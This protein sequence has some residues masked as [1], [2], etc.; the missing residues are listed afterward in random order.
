MEPFGPLMAFFCVHHF[1]PTLVSEWEICVAFR[2]RVEGDAERRD[3]LI[4][5]KKRIDSEDE[6]STDRLRNRQYRVAIERQRGYG[7][8][9]WVNLERERKDAGMVQRH[10][11]CGASD[12]SV[13]LFRRDIR[14]YNE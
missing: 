13:T 7:P 2:K 8:D 11:N 12:C 10:W 4:E 14:S 6:N 5:I 1:E 9:D 3:T